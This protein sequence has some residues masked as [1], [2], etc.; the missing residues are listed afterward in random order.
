MYVIK[1]QEGFYLAD[2]NNG[3]TIFRKNLKDA[4]TFNSRGG[5]EMTFEY[6]NLSNVY[7]SVEEVPVE[8]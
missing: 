5:A 2:F 1:N 3:N 6:Y 8:I 4:F 7:C